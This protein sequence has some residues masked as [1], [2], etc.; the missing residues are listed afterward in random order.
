MKIAPHKLGF[1]FD[2]VIA[3]IAEAFMRL[4]CTEYNYCSFTLEDIVSFHVEKCLKIPEDI[5]ESIFLDILQ[6]SVATGLVP[7][8]GAMEVMQELTAV[9][10]VQI[11]TA[12]SQSLP[13]EKW[14]DK[15]LPDSA[16]KK[17]HVTAMGDHDNK[18]QF[19]HDFGLSHFIDDRTETC[20]QLAESNITPIVFAQPWNKNSHS[21]TSVT[22]WDELRGMV[23]IA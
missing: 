3:D 21:F 6:D 18:V 8:P 23:D 22:N 15:F 10:D 9:S 1:D 14:L 16:V 13:V 12:R 20:R 2:G 5:V 7:M 11:I 4:A 19:V 17:I